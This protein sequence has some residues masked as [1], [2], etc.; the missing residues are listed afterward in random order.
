MEHLELLG[1]FFSGLGM[2]FLGIA[3][4]WFV[5]VYEK[6]NKLRG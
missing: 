5:S 6:K 4:F 2:F 3:A 1:E